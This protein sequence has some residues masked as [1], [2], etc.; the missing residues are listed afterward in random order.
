MDLMQLMD[1]LIV[2]RQVRALTL[3]GRW[4]FCGRPL[5]WN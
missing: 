5:F 2:T 3:Q 4:M 1:W